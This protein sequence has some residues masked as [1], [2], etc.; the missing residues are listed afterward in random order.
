MAEYT[1]NTTAQ[2]YCTFEPANMSR[3]WTIKHWQLATANMLADSLHWNQNGHS[4]SSML[5]SCIC[6]VWYI[7]TVSSFGINIYVYI[8]IQFVPGCIHTYSLALYIGRVIL[9]NMDL[10]I[11]SYM[12]LFRMMYRLLVLVLYIH[13]DTHGMWLSTGTSSMRTRGLF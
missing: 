13:P 8:Y 5:P 10:F 12:S 4:K 1:G 7:W 6:D 11:L 2:V 3:T 9:A